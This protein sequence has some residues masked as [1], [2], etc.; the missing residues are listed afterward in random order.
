MAKKWARYLPSETGKEFLDSYKKNLNDVL[1]SAK[2]QRSELDTAAPSIISDKQDDIHAADVE[3]ELVQGKN[4]DSFFKP[5]AEGNTDDSPSKSSRNRDVPNNRSKQLHIR[6]EPEDDSDDDASL[7]S[8]PEESDTEETHVLP[9]T[10]STAI[11][12][13]TDVSDARSLDHDN[14]SIMKL[15]DRINEFPIGCL[16]VWH[17]D[18]NSFRSGMVTSPPIYGTNKDTAY[19]V[20]P[21]KS[22][23][24][25]ESITLV[26][27]KALAFGLD[28]PVYVSRGSESHLL[29][30][31]ILFCKTGSSSANDSQADSFSYTILIIKEGNKIQVMND[32]S[33]E[34]VKY[35]KVIIPTNK[36]TASADRGSDVIH[37]EVPSQAK[38][39]S[40][41]GLAPAIFTSRNKAVEEN[42]SQTSSQKFFS[43]NST[44][45]S[46]D[47][48]PASSRRAIVDGTSGRDGRSSVL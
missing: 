24:E 19:E 46:V 32:V 1:G 6:S 25:H 12:R 17:F 22:S 43:S 44:I 8:D 4:P 27:G 41:A 7:F 21:I 31:K 26:L 15:P 30:G 5:I 38:K 11:V 35:R 23:G 40:T 29:E 33:S 9:D 39:T 28:C 2:L 42:N 10:N 45:T 36:N 16:V 37:N 18:C 34:R 14:G 13:A 47:S 20:M 3:I 48:A